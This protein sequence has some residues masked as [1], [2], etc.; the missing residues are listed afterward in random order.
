MFSRDG[1]K[2]LF[3]RSVLGKGLE[4]VVANPDGSGS[5]VVSPPVNGLDQVDWSPDG[6]RIVFLPKSRALP[7]TRSTS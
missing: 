4:L 7:G 1:T 3:L 2:L 5:K 6:S